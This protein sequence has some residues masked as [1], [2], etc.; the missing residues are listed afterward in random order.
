MLK[1]SAEDEAFG[2]MLRKCAPSFRIFVHERL[3]PNG[4][5]KCRVVIVHPIYMSVRRDFGVHIG[6]LEEQ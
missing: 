5:K 2:E 3:H 6:F 4:H 1:Y